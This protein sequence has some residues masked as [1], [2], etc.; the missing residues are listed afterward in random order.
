MRKDPI[1]A[2]QQTRYFSETKYLQGGE[3]EALGYSLTFKTL[4]I[5]SLDAM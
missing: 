4:I 1:S 2:G 3:R 5:S